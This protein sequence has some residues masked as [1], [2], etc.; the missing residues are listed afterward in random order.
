[1]CKKLL[2]VT[3]R[4]KYANVKLQEDVQQGECC[5]CQVRYDNYK[6]HVNSR[7]HI[8]RFREAMNSEKNMIQ[9][10]IAYQHQFERLQAIQAQLTNHCSTLC[11]RE[12]ISWSEACEEVNRCM[13]ACGAPIYADP[14]D[15]PRANSPTVKRMEF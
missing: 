1:M 2:S 6:E 4:D 8:K 15:V 3:S 9:Q 13:R 10:L 7:E 12:L 11:G 5:V 14:S